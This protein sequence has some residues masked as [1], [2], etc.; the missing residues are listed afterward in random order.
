MLQR[1]M[2]LFDGRLSPR[3]T[4]VAGLAVAVVLLVFASV[5]TVAGAIG[6]LFFV[7]AGTE[8]LRD[9]VAYFEERPRLAVLVT[10]FCSSAVV[11][12]SFAA[13]RA[14]LRRR[15]ETDPE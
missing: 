4:R 9:H 6:I 5:L 2:H 3:N 13:G 12:V 15:P 14:S 1:G 11:I 8:W 7:G 10:L